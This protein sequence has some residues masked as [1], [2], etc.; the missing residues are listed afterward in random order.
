ML[1]LAEASMSDD[2]RP[3]VQA[4][5][6][7]WKPHY[8]K[9]GEI[10]VGLGWH[11]ARDGVSLVAQRPNGRLYVGPVCVS[12]QAS[13]RRG[14]VQHGHRAHDADLLKKFCRPRSA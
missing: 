10:R 14:A 9:P 8:G 13:G 7:A 1:K 4:I 5:H 12:A 11:L 3:V 2:N 6:E